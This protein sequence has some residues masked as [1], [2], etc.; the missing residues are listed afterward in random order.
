M[1]R[2]ITGG[3]TANLLAGIIVTIVTICGTALWM[4]DQHDRQAA[5]ATQ[6]M[7]EG[8]VDL[9]RRR[10][11]AITNDYAWWDE[12]FDAYVRDDA[13]WL[14]ANIGTGITGTMIADALVILGLDGKIK[15]QWSI[16]DAIY[17]PDAIFTPTVVSWAA[18]MMADTPVD[19][20]AAKTLFAM[21]HDG[22]VHLISVQRLTPPTRIDTIPKSQMPL[23][24]F[25][26]ELTPERLSEL[27]S[28]YLLPDLRVV[29]GD[30][31][32]AGLESNASILSDPEGRSIGTLVWT[33]P[34]PGH[35]LL[36]KVAIP[37]TLAVLVF[38]LVA[39]IIAFRARGMALALTRSEEEAIVAS[40]TDSLT[41][42][43]NR[44]GFTH[45][46]HLPEALDACRTGRL[47]V[48]YIDVNEFKLVND[49]LGHHAGDRLVVA[50]ARRLE[51]KMPRDTV[52]ARIGGDE[53]G[54]V[55]MGDDLDTRVPALCLTFAAAIEEP[56]DILGKKLQVHC[57][58]GYAIAP[59][60]AMDPAEI[61]RRSDVAMYNA[62][63]AREREGVVYDPRMELGAEEKRRI[64]V[65]LRDA[66][67]AG[68][69]DISYQ[70]I[71]STET[72]EIDHVEALV[73]WNSREL[74]NVGPDR[75]IPIAE[76]TGLIHEIGAFVIERTCRD[77]ARWPGVTACIN[78]SPVQ[79]RDP[80][81]IET[82]LRIV[83]AL[84]VDPRRIELELT[85]GVL[86][87]VPTIA[88]MRLDALKAAGFSLALDDFGTGFSSIGY[89]EQF[90]FDNLKIDKS[91]LAEL[92]KS[93]K[94]NALVHSLVS[95]GQAMGL[96]VTA[97]GVE[98]VH[99][100]DLL[101]SIRCTRMQGWLI[102]RP[103]SAEALAKVLA[104]GD[105]YKGATTA[106]VAQVLAETGTGPRKPIALT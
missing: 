8:G 16:D 9:T 35:E 56:F 94:G 64:E 3:I 4:A 24:M 26:Q 79:L 62:K 44:T 55:A 46:L 54:V 70:P 96:S 91:F 80:A 75:F 90:P 21:G 60:G 11:E 58:I 29:A 36:K 66:I 43:L 72:R 5:E 82:I 88:K 81:F 22:L 85:E 13:E 49:A 39:M 57:A 76:Q 27:G 73:R 14:D 69:L 18:R 28:Q 42:L 10:L 20:S 68:E 53:F 61:V 48:I 25:V 2:A 6:T 78:L 15:H 33:A 89:L 74:G 98:T 41:G 77:L 84:D 30:A 47:A 23:I 100:F 86:V 63:A 83:S 51:A 95:L 59:G 34:H 38:A 104:T 92:G 37:I 105:Y 19:R 71:L 106:G 31:V 7:V 12:A 45:R 102:G 93:A 40:R 17:P 32:P 87:T 67:P 65:V 52:F 1:S 101:R 50:L 103:M 97:E 99:Q